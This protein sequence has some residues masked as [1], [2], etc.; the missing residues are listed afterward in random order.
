[1]A[2]PTRG[3]QTAVLPG[4]ILTVITMTC[5]PRTTDPEATTGH[6]GVV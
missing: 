5:L 6:R 4:S 2:R 1:M 3:S